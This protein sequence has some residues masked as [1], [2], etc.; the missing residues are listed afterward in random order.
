MKMVTKEGLE[1]RRIRTAENLVELKKLLNSQ[2]RQWRSEN[3][4]VLDHILR[5]IPKQKTATA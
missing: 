1:K 2:E 5:L 3:P 4:E